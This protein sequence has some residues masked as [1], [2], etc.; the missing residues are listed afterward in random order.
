MPM[1]KTILY[2]ALV[3][4]VMSLTMSLVAD[5][6][7]VSDQKTAETNS[8]DIYVHQVKH[9]NQEDAQGRN[10]FQSELAVELK[11]L[12]KISLQK[13]TPMLEKTLG[14]LSKLKA[15]IVRMQDALV[16]PENKPVF[17][18]L[19]DERV[20]PV[21]TGTNWIDS[22][23]LASNGFTL[24]DRIQKQLTELNYWEQ[25]FGIH[26]VP[27]RKKEPFSGRNIGKINGLRLAIINAGFSVKFDKTFSIWRITGT[28]APTIH[29]Q[30]K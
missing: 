28:N 29:V 20:V 6:P 11:K 9:L 12:D 21:W 17:R 4:M 23:L 22:H 27:E 19:F 16:F 10:D 26:S 14:L 30:E 1:K 7:P 15:P 13:S 3:A 24:S 18:Q 5:T 2:T 25:N 8:F